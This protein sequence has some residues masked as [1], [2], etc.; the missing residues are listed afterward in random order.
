MS[1]DSHPLMGRPIAGPSALGGD[2]RR[3]LLLTWT[4]AVTEFKLRFFGS[5]LGY[6]WTLMRPLMLF[7][8]LYVV[9]TQFITVSDH[10]LFPAS[11]LLGVV[12]FTF[13]AEATGGAVRS[14]VDRENLVRKIHFPRMAIPLSVVLLATINFALNMIVVLIFGLAVGIKFHWTWLEMPFLL[15]GLAMFATG[16]AM[17]LSALYV[18]FRDL[19]PIWEVVL[20]MVFYG[21]LIIVPFETVAAKYETLAKLLLINPVAAVIEQ[22]RYAFVDQD[23]PA[24]ASAMGGVVTLLGPI[25]IT[26]VTFFLGLWVFNRAAPRVAEEL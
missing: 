23:I 4:L 2:W 24:A 9:F 3:F 16:C 25:T 26:L 12:L 18:R 8:V 10:P 7:G 1:A 15:V 13:F 6:V 22:A 17:L 5:I 19:E 11:L 20:Q 21:S 14:V